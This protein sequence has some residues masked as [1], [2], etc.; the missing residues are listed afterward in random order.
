MAL[1]D[2]RRDRREVRAVRLAATHARRLGAEREMRL[3]ARGELRERRRER[4]VL[5]EARGA[6]RRVA[7]GVVGRERALEERG[8]V[9]VLGLG[10]RAEARAVDL[11]GVR[12]A[13][14]HHLRR[15]DERAAKRGAQRSDGA[16]RA[17][18]LHLVRR[19]ALQRGIELRFEASARRL[20]DDLRAR[21]RRLPRGR[22][23]TRRLSAMTR[24]AFRFCVAIPRPTCGFTYTRRTR[25][26]RARSDRWRDRKLR[27]PATA[28]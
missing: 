21:D 17:G 2:H 23:P 15:L 6:Q 25:R 20:V 19:L 28:A 24:F 11:A 9:A 7:A 14:H 10:E 22:S 16:E 5:A 1:L 8:D 18:E 3:P 13:A 12:A 27:R 4:G 26:G